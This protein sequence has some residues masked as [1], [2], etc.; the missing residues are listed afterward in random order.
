MQ[1]NNLEVYGVIY[2][3]TNNINNKVYIG[4]T[5]R[6]FDRR[7]YH[8]GTPIEKVYKYHVY[9]KSKGKSYNKHLLGAIEKYG[10]D[11]FS[12][13]KVFDVAFSKE[14]L[15][16]KEKSWIAIFNSNNSNYGYNFTTGGQENSKINE[17]TKNKIRMSHLGNNIDY[18]LQL[19]RDMNIINKFISLKVASDFLNIKY[20]L[21]RDTVSRRQKTCRGYVFVRE[22]YY[23]DNFKNNK[24]EY[25][26]L[27]KFNDT[28]I[29][30]TVICLTTGEIFKRVNDALDKYNM[31]NHI[32]EV[33]KGKRNYC[34]KLEDGTPLRWMYYEDYLNV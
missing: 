33:C 9:Y 7:Y 4:Q 26:K 32:S 14:E 13:N 34:G 25:D 28:N 11:N 18:I 15:D 5:T 3:I 29:K 10:F 16:I 31:S 1:L 22:S 24:S 30:N 12:I 19:D 8:S 6:S 2:K 27:Y 23:I 20:E 21:I 17:E